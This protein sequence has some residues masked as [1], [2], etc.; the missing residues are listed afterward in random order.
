MLQKINERIQGVVAWT[1]IILI[2]VTFSL[3][4]IDYYIQS[5]D[6]GQTE[7]RVNGEPISK[8]LFE[9][10]FRR[11]R[12]MRDATLNSQ[13]SEKLLK[14]KTLE[15]MIDN[16]VVKQGAQQL[17]FYVSNAEADS[18]ILSI[19]QFQLDGRFS[20]SRY[21]QALSTA[22]YTPETFQHQV[23]LGMLIN[24]QR[25]AF[26]GTAF[27]LP[28]EVDRF[29]KLYMQKRTYDTCLISANLFKQKVNVSEQAIKD[30][31]ETHR[32]EFITPE[33]IK[34]EFVR[35]S[36]DALK[37]QVKV[38]EA[39]LK[40]Y[41]ESNQQSFTVP[42]QWKVAHILLSFP[43]NALED[44][45]VQV[46][47]KA[48]KT[49]TALSRHPEQFES[50]VQRVSDDKLSA[51]H[52]GELPWIS[53]G[54]TPFDKA[55]LTLKKSGDLT[56]PVLTTRGYEIF[57]L[58]D[59]KQSY[60]KPFKTVQAQI[61]EELIHDQLQTSY[62]EQLEKL[63]DLTYQT[64]DTLSTV[65]E[66]LNIPIEKTEFFTRQGT[67]SGISTHEKV[68]TAAF[69]PDVLELGNNSEPIQLDDNTVIVLRVLDRQKSEQKPFSEV[70]EAIVKTLTDEKASL[71]AQKFGDALL[72]RQHD[73]AFLDQALR[74][75]NLS[76]VHSQE[77]PRD[78]S[79]TQNPQVNE[80]AFSLSKSRPLG[81]VRLENGDYAVVRLIAIH[82]GQFDSLDKEL[83]AS[84]AQ[85]IEA[86]DGI[87]DYNVYMKDLL[88]R[89]KIEH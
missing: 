43:K 4:G 78:H 52:Q 77:N 54:T 82:D 64:P 58:I 84:I 48:E 74:E 2:T 87:N 17:G 89:A 36:M 51:R 19:P 21:E 34:I 55:L 66:A 68:L 1:V 20:Q 38:T 49:Y 60:T 23:Q 73:K 86:S 9:L 25:F 26:M 85:Q 35:L 81:G 29:V 10:Q 80:F 39:S 24:Q 79:I 31:Y 88:K 75:K 56:K 33:H 8:Q 42:T 7:V 67:K 62:A 16:L 5:K 40:S 83:Q 14:K 6:S 59:I 65:S 76:W 72:A 57:K 28:A 11:E 50:L 18:A 22:L 37:K 13:E 69:N 32:Q 71:A 47:Q 41:Y 45:K 61:R 3:F 27:A 12:Q 70:R 46:K 53:A 15:D 44:A 30:Y 63:S